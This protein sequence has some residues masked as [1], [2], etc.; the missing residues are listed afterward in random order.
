MA[1]KSKSR[2]TSGAAPAPKKTAAKKRARK[3]AGGLALSISLAKARRLAGDLY[4]A[5]GNAVWGEAIERA[6][7][8]K[9]SQ[10]IALQDAICDAADALGGAKTASVGANPLRLY[11]ILG[12]DAPARFVTAATEAE[13]LALWTAA[14]GDASPGQ[15]RIVLAP[16]PAEAP[17]L[18]E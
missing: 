3:S 14:F 9:R 1:K 7:E 18:H 13:A 8:P 16:H 6:A 11:C 10:L 5:A 17:G 12:D 15:P 2:P 4:E